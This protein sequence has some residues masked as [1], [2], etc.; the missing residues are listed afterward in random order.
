MGGKIPREFLDELLARVDIVDVVDARVPLKKQGREHVACCPFHTEKTPSFTVSAQKQFYHCFGCGAHGTA[1]GFL[2][3]Y[4]KLEFLDAVEVL[5]ESVGMEVPRTS[6]RREGG[7]DP[8]YELLEE[9]TRFYQDALKRSPTAVD[10]LKGRGLSGEVA[11]QY[12]LGFAPPG[13]DALLKRFS[14]RA[15]PDR[16]QQLGLVV[17]NDRGRV[18]DRFRNRI[19]FPIRDRRGRTLGFGG[20]VLDDSKPKYLNSPETQLFHKGRSLYGDFEARSN[21]GAHEFILVVEG[22]MDVV[23]LAGHGFHNTV[24]TLGTA[25]T[26]FHL[27][28]L[29][30]D[31]S[32]VVFCFDGDQAG[33]DAAWRALET[34]V[35]IHRDGYEAHFLFLPD[36]EDPDSLVRKEGREGFGHRVEESISLS[37]FLFKHFQ[38]QADMTSAAG[39]ARLADQIKGVLERMTD[40]VYRDL[41]YERLA[42][43]VGIRSELLR[44]PPDQSASSAASRPRWRQALNTPVRAAIA[45]MLDD[46]DLVRRLDKVERFKGSDTPGVELF[47]ELVET[48]R[49]D[50]HLTPAA[51]VERYRGGDTHQH[52]LKLM[53]WCPPER[54]SF[55][56]E[57]EFSDSLSRMRAVARRQRTEILLRA[58]REQGLTATEKAEL[59][60]LLGGDAVPS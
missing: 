20:R 22:Y 15:S 3:D 2:M 14:S 6:A 9:V 36:G 28:S 50:P 45:L 59:G 42:R 26:P 31:V 17:R 49:A 23:V 24:A 55:D 57:R 16:L 38:S 40:G 39:K 30:R 41:L 43:T 10:Y 32:R 27:E 44:A 29:F 21:R 25:T 5:A 48:F 60:R 56:R 18:Y 33:R 11:A 13:W 8:G 12:A 47:W 53:E 35:P 58:E 1:L 7:S 34:L 46:P 51:A 4:E 37:D 52:L 54:E 19:M